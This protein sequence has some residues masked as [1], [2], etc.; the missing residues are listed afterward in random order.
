MDVLKDPALGLVGRV[1]YQRE[2]L[3]PAPLLSFEEMAERFREVIP[4][5]VPEPDDPSEPGR[6]CAAPVREVV[7]VLE[8]PAEVVDLARVVDV[9][10]QHR[11]NDQPRLA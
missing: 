7:G 9:V 8:Q 10:D 5:Y 6:L 11:I 1:I 4:G 3:E 2:M